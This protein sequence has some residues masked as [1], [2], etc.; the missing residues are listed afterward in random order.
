MGW[1]IGPVVASWAVAFL[2]VRI[3]DYV[4]GGATNKVV[5]VT[6]AGLFVSAWTAVTAGTGMRGFDKRVRGLRRR[7]R[8]IK[9]EVFN[10]LT[11]V[12]GGKRKG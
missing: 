7:T 6:R 9:G 11:R 10:A 5:D 8:G 12:S 2:V 1:L 3:F 4:V